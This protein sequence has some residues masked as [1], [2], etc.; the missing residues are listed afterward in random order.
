MAGGCNDF[1]GMARERVRVAPFINVPEGIAGPGKQFG[2]R[3]IL[4]R[5]VCR[6]SGG[7]FLVFLR[8]Q[9]AE[10]VNP[11]IHLIRLECPVFAQGCANVFL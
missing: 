9:D 4:R 1:L 5:L 6:D 10:S 7:W 2:V 8:E 3:L 11:G